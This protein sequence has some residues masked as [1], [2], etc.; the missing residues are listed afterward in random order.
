L[1]NTNFRRGNV[2]KQSGIGEDVF[3]LKTVP[4]DS[5]LN[6]GQIVQGKGTHYGSHGEALRRRQYDR[7][8]TALGWIFAF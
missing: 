4:P 3:H 5:D 1:T 7:K 6:A 2:V 8:S